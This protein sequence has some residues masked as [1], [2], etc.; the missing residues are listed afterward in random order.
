LAEKLIHTRGINE[1]IRDQMKKSEMVRLSGLSGQ[2]S[3]AVAI[4]KEIE[5][6]VDGDAGDFFGALNTKGILRLN[7]TSSRFLGD[8]MVGGAI[9]V[10][11]NC[12]SGLGTNMHGGIIIVKGNVG[13]T[14]GQINRGGTIIVN[15]DAGDRV[16]FSM[17]NGNIII[18]GNTGTETGHWMLHGNI[19]VGGKIEGLGDNTKIVSLEERDLRKLKT[20]FR[21]YGIKIDVGKFKKIVSIDRRALKNFCVPQLVPQ[22][23][24]LPSNHEVQG[25]RPHRYRQPNSPC[26]DDF[27]IVP[28]QLGK[29]MPK[30][31]V[32]DDINVR[33]VIGEN[34]VKKPLTL[35]SPVLVSCG[36][37]GEVSKSCK[38]AYAHGSAIGGAAVI[39]GDGGLLTEEIRALRDHNGKL[40][41]QWTPGR[42][43]LKPE[44]IRLADAVAIDFTNSYGYSR[45]RLLAEKLSAKVAEMRSIPDDVD[46]VS[47]AR[48]P[49]IERRADLRK[50]V[51]LIREVTN[52]AIP[53]IINLIGSDVSNDVKISAQ[54]GADAIVVFGNEARFVG[55]TTAPSTVGSIGIPLLGVFPVALKALRETGAD[56]KGVRLLVAGGIRD[57]SDIF[58]ILALGADGV[59]IDTPVQTLV[60]CTGC[61]KCY[62]GR[63][64]QGIA[65][66]DPNLEAKLDWQSTGRSI[67]NFLKN[68]IENL[69][70][71]TALCGHSD[72]R[73]INPDDI[74]ATRYDAAALTGVKLVG[75]EKLLP[76]W[77][78]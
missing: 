77:E 46:V 28:A 64:P 73:E 18:T 26:F 74:R 32:R 58:K 48:F 13:D 23:D 35:K 69:R 24:N 65:T 17:F 55:R 38:L 2:D 67:G 53:V 33:I 47:P 29:R 12:G 66:H 43:G 4:E 44:H 7:G 42:F 45:E 75:Y 8:F 72:I 20:Y 27:V 56:K 63:C 60:G 16:G 49:D 22:S 61:N 11:G 37:F 62:L 78:H 21:H 68:T 41:I 14:V 6:T 51:E 59:V 54:A 5:I 50:H 40:I 39:T 52:H 31:P 57:G 25:N 71:L 30:D 15:G 10:N 70:I 34:R 36:S 1:A 19:Y 9:F 3:I 76:I